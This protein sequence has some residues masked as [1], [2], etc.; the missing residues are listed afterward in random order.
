[1]SL[2]IHCGIDFDQAIAKDNHDFYFLMNAWYLTLFHGNQLYN[3][4]R[5]VGFSILTVVM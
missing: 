2:H 1:M 5:E 3:N 4:L